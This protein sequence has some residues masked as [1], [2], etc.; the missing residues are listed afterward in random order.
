MIFNSLSFILICLL[1]CILI[2]L[3]MERFGGAMRIKAEN[4]VILLF[5]VLFYAWSGLRFLA[6]LLCLIAVNYVIGLLSLRNRYFAL[7][8]TAVNVAI[9]CFF[10]YFNALLGIMQ[11]RFEAAGG[12]AEVMAPIGIS[13]IVFSC[14]SYMMDIYSGKAEICRNVLKFALYILLFPKLLQGPIAKYQDMKGQIDNRSISFDGFMSGLERFLIGMSKKVLIADILAQT[15]TDIFSNMYSGIDAGTAWIGIFSYTLCLYMD[16]SGY[17][18]MAIGV[19]RMLGF[20][21]KENFNFPYLSASPGEFWRRWH[22]S[23]GSFFK[24]YLYF[25]LGGSRK[26]NVYVNL[27]IVFIVT[28]MWHGSTMIYLFWGA[29]HG[30]FV[31][32]DR[33]LSEKG[34]TDKIPNV[35]R[36]LITFMIV[37][38]GW[39]AFN[40]GTVRDFV[41]YILLMLGRGAA[42]NFTYVYYLNPRLIVICAAVVL[43]GIIA[44]NEKVRTRFKRLNEGSIV[45]NIIKYILMIVCVYL[46]FITGLSEGYSPFLYFQF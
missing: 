36:T 42:S 20:E 9:L 46:C 2:V 16:F 6:L 17:S 31:L 8:G 38:V 32:L 39:I 27:M 29:Y 37:M 25:P 12:I 1:P 14:I 44:G 24:E 11:S 30:F 35:I 19:S 5:S 41:N 10:K 7:A 22:I 13:F 3:V 28:G 34:V 18:D 21:L 4:A 15:S 26:G 45:F 43:G 23:L 40:V 33:W